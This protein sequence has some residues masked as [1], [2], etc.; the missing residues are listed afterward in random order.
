MPSGSV[1]WDI[2][3]YTRTLILN[4]TLPNEPSYQRRTPIL[5]AR[6]MMGVTLEPTND[7][8]IFI[9][10]PPKKMPL[11]LHTWFTKCP[12]LLCWQG[13]HYSK[14][15]VFTLSRRAYFEYC[16]CFPYSPP[17]SYFSICVTAGLALEMIK[18]II[19]ISEPFM[20]SY[21]SLLLTAN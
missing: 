6:E 7:V 10:P 19:F 13:L 11:K 17:L 4:H 15:S 3:L 16:F 12:R 5:G 1:G 20:L 14:L 18:R 21:S 2:S 9:S 8:L